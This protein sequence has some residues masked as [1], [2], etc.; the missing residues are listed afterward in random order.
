VP[1]EV[2]SGCEQLGCENVTLL[3]F[4]P[5]SM[6]GNDLAPRSAAAVVRAMADPSLHGPRRGRTGKP[7][8]KWAARPA[9]FT[10][11]GECAHFTAAIVS[12][13]ACSRPIRMISRNDRML[14][15]LTLCCVRGQGAA[16]MVLT[17]LRPGLAG[18][19]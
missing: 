10:S 6:H 3:A 17:E 13:P 14:V 11:Q 15:N 8:I 7:L 9:G 1:A 2:Q 12:L 4:P 18:G 5:V 16:G 19:R